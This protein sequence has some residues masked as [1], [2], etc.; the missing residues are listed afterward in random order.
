LFGVCFFSVTFACDCIRYL[1]D[2]P[3][4]ICAYTRV[5]FLVFIVCIVVEV[6]DRA[7]N[8]MRQGALAEIYK[9]MADTDTLTGLNNRNAL[10]F[11]E[12][13]YNEYTRNGRKMA[14]VMFDVNDLKYVNDTYGHDKGD[15]LITTAAQIIKDS[16]G[17]L[18]RCH[19]TGGDEFIAVLDCEDVEESYDKALKTFLK[20]IRKYNKENKNNGFE[21]EIAYGVHMSDEETVG[22]MRHKADE[23]MYI[24]K[25]EMKKDRK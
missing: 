19:R 3:D 1:S 10:V 21:L 11:D 16:F 4:D 25:K 2:I 15:S 22:A 5:G 13:R 12:Y 17:E 6:C 9:K 20:N 7:V 18:G 8:V 24:K 14:V 23:L